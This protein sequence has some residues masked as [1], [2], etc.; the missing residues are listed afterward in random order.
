MTSDIPDWALA[1]TANMEFD[2]K[3]GR[4][5]FSD[6]SLISYFIERSS[7]RLIDQVKLLFYYN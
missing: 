7:I 1:Q 2:F 5:R 3:T 6:T 4:N